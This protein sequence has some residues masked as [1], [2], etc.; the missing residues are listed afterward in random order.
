MTDR[1]LAGFIAGIV[2]SLCVN[3]KAEARVTT[4]SSSLL[5]RACK[6]M[7][8][9]IAT[10][11]GIDVVAA[12][13]DS[14]AVST[15]SVLCPGHDGWS[16]VFTERDGASWIGLRKDGVQDDG[17]SQQE[18][19][20]L[21]SAMEISFFSQ[22][23]AGSGG[24]YPNVIGKNIEWRFHTES[25]RGVGSLDA[26]ARGTARTSKLHALIVHTNSQDVEDPAKAHHN[27][28][29]IRIH[30]ENVSKSCWVGSA[31]RK[32]LGRQA[33]PRARKIADDLSLPCL[34]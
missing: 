26:G 8:V 33:L 19:E 4:K 31:D 7:S 1:L 18:A 6:P 24:E 15:D 29:V 16:V 3:S 5:S 28:V 34:P 23:L 21:K 32:T 20:G 27:Y 25:S 14:R 17:L 13:G 11:D 9:G 30:P 22:I 10:I 12:V 2:V